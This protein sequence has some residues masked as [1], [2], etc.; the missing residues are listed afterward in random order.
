M[1]IGDRTYEVT[2]E[3]QQVGLQVKVWGIAVASETATPAEAREL[4]RL[5]LAAADVAEG[6]PVGQTVT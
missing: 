2:A 1:K 3:R 4:G 5:L 6:K